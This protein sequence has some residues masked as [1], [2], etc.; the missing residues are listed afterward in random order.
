[1]VWVCPAKLVH[2]AT[3]PGLEHL[4]FLYCV[5]VLPRIVFMMLCYAVWQIILK[6]QL[7]LLSSERERVFCSVPF[8]S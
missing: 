5:S 6:V 7:S 3:L 4:G 2:Q 8:Y 1:M